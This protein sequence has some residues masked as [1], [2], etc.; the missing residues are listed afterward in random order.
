[1]K[2]KPIDYEKKLK[3]SSPTRGLELGPAEWKAAILATRP[4]S[5]LRN[6]DKNF[7]MFSISNIIFFIRAG[8]ALTREE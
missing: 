2:K 6:Q 8:S 3:K 5:I 1:M 7:A 4:W